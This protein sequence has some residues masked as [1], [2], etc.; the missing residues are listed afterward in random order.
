MGTARSCWAWKPTG[1]K[2]G[3]AGEWAFFADT[4]FGSGLV[5]RDAVANGRDILRVEGDG[6]VRF[7]EGAAGFDG[8]DGWRDCVD[9]G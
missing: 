8:R 9:F 6:E 1:A 7:G 5:L 3:V 4:G 2:Q